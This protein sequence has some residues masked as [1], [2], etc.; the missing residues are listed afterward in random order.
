LRKFHFVPALAGD[1]LDDA[2][3]R[4]LAVARVDALG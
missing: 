4:V 2:L 3:E 1:D